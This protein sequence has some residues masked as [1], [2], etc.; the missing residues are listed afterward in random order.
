MSIEEKN[1]AMEASIID[2][3]NINFGTAKDKLRGAKKAS[4]SVKSNFAPQSVASLSRDMIMQFP[5]I[6]SNTIP[7][8]EAMQIARALERQYAAF[9][10]ITLSS[11]F[12]VDEGKFATIQDF[13]K[14]IH[15]NDDAPKLLDYAFGLTSN[16]DSLHHAQESTIPGFSSDELAALWYGSEDEITTE[17]LNSL[18]LPNT[19]NVTKL[20]AVLEAK[21]E[22]N[23]E[24]KSTV[25][26]GIDDGKALANSVPDSVKLKENFNPKV[27]DKN[28]SNPIS[29]L[30]PTLITAQLQVKTAKDTFPRSITLGVKTMVR[31]AS[32]NYMITNLANAATAH[33][34]AFNLIKWTKGEIKFFKDLI[35]DISNSRKNAIAERDGGDWFSA[36]ER[37]KKNSKAFVGGGRPLSPIRTIVCTDSEI[38]AVKEETGVDLENPKMA[39]KLVKD[40]FLL[41]FVI[42]SPSSQVVKIMLDGNATGGDF[43]MTTIQALSAANKEGD[44]ISLKDVAKLIGAR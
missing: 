41:G 4:F 42:Y 15:N 44:K 31:L 36:N 6:M 28:I 35:F 11:S 1:T 10:L 34:F 7:T 20:R 30:E 32:S 3:K 13:V 24:D 5:V 8:D 37:R 38:Q 14:S 33:T 2:I 12:T 18:Y 25:Q 22:E 23:S 16:I 29:S 26:K 43:S 21:N 9:S 39:K 17:S 27:T 19:R 40:L